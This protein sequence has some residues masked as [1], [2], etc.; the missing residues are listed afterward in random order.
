MAGTFKFELVTP[1]KMLIPERSDDAGK[2]AS[3]EAEQVVVPGAD[4]QFTVLAGHAPV[5]SALRPGILEIKL[6]TGL[7]RV[8]VRGGFAEVEPD[9]LTILAQ[10]FVDLD[11]KDSG[12]INAE[13]KSAEALLAIAKDDSDRQVAQDAITQLKALA[14]A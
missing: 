11:S 1:E 10:N 8:F 5:I 12:K 14:T 6:T 3:A 9:R 2:M 7:R 13:L 4:G